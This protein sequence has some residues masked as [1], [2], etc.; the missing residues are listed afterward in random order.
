MLLFPGLFFFFFF[1]QGQ[2]N[3]PERVGPVSLK[4][5]GGNAAGLSRPSLAVTLSRRGS[6]AAPSPPSRPGRLALRLPPSPA[7]PAP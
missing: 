5:L 1:L 3:V 4:D 2:R 7:A 6:A